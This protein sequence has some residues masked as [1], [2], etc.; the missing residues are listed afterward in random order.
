MSNVSVFGW[1]RAV[2][3]MVQNRF[4]SRPALNCVENILINC[5]NSDPAFLLNIYFNTICRNNLFFAKASSGGFFALFQ[6]D[7]QFLNR[8]HDTL[9]WFALLQR[10]PSTHLR[11]PCTFYRHCPRRNECLLTNR[12]WCRS[13]YCHT[14]RN[15]NDKTIRVNSFKDLGLAPL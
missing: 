15:V 10:R 1:A 7:N 6:S 8:L 5:Q 11:L 3:R 12:L 9:S 14:M 2:K 13:V 4:E